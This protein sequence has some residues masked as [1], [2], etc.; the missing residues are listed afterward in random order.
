M[1]HRPPSPAAAIEVLR[2]G[3]ERFAADRSEHPN[4]SH[5]VRVASAHVQEPFAA[6][7]GCADSRVPAELVFDC[8]IGDLFV[9]RVAANV[10]S[11]VN[12]PSLA[13]AVGTLGVRVVVVLAH[14]R[15]GG[16]S[17]ALDA[18]V[19]RI[20]PGELAPLV[21]AV[22][23]AIDVCCPDGVPA[24]GSEDEDLVDRVVATNARITAAAL[25]EGSGIIGGA[26]EA[27]TCRV[28]PAVYSLTTARVTF[29]DS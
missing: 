10:T 5:E 1:P 7:L 20:D 4:I 15:C 2:E 29:L 17:A 3:N 26:V 28:V 12:R 18:V 14:Q 13:F 25:V 19:G 8:G 21:E 22:R 11:D 23:P 9:C 24:A 6:V 27:G 16:V